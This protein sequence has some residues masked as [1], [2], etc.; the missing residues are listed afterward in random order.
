MEEQKAVSEVEGKEV[1]EVS[2]EELA[3]LM[4][5]GKKHQDAEN[6]GDGV[7]ADYILLAKTGTKALKKTQTDLYIQGLAIGDFFLQKEKKVLGDK[8]KVVPLA[9]ITLYQ[10]KESRDM[11]AKFFGVWNKAQAESFPLV[12]GSY[13]DRQLPNGHILQPVNWV[14][15]EV[16]GHPE[17][18]NAVITYKSTGS[19][20]W[21][22]WKED[23]KPRSQTSATLIYEISELEVSNDKNEWTDIGFNY[24]GSLLETDKAMAVKC[25]KKSNAIRGAYENKTLVS[26]HVV[27][28]VSDTKAVARIEDASDVEESYDDYE[29]GF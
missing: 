13:F 12:D 2:D 7:K 20:L 16:L 27:A 8:L 1:A 6:S 26:D 9:F 23:A 28:S 25:L 10:E 21:R 4:A 5:E 18:E 14:C 11:N 3:Q 19:R 29:N 24:V 15:V 22:K 17:I